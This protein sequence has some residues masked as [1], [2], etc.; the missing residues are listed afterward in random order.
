MLTVG[1]RADGWRGATL[2]LAEAVAVSAGPL[3]ES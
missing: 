2:K 1:P 3:T